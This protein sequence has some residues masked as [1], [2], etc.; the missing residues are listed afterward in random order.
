MR[1][2]VTVILL[3]ICM[4]AGGMLWSGCDSDSDGSLSA[5]ELL[6]GFW[7][8]N[9]VSMVGPA[10]ID[11]IGQLVAGDVFDPTII[12]WIF[13]LHL[14]DDNT[15]TISQSIFGEVPTVEAGTWSADRSEITLHL[16]DQTDVYP[17]TRRGDTLTLHMAEST[18][19]EFPAD[20]EMVR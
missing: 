15:Y 8:L 12:A 7:L 9:R 1:R 11:V 3:T 10:E 20:L 18:T 5:E 13:S 19:P 14:R 2:Y 16:G 17:Y 6:V 4:M